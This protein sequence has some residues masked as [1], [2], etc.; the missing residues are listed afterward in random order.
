MSCVTEELFTVSSDV[1]EPSSSLDSSV[2]SLPV[3]Y[4]AL[5]LPLARQKISLVL[6]STFSNYSAVFI[7]PQNDIRLCINTSSYAHVNTISV[8]AFTYLLSVLMPEVLGCTYY[9]A[10][11]FGCCSRPAHMFGCCS[12]PAHM[13]GCC[14]SRPAHMFGCCC[15][16]PAHMFGCCC[17]R[18]AH[19][20]GCCCS[21]PASA[22]HM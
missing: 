17:S 4:K 2:K 20:F 16:R 12:R 13:F 5:K 7:S 21:R 15:S 22:S 1:K 10:E 18:P 6:L 8:F 3:K 19:M 11:M 9:L 14:C